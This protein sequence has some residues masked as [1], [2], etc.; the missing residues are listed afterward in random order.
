MG[1]RLSALVSLVT[2]TRLP[3]AGFWEGRGVLVTGHTGFKGS[4]LVHWLARLGAR[5]HGLALDPP[6]T[7]S[8]FDTA[9]TGDLLASDTRADVR[10]AD[11]VRTA[12][13]SS[14]ASIVL[15]LAAQPLVRDG[16]RHPSETFETNVIGTTNLLE[17][18]RVT[19]DVAAL[20]VVTTDKVYRPRDPSSAEQDVPHRESDALGAED[21]YAWS[22]VMVEHA[23][24][25]FHDLPAIDGLPGWSAPVATARAGNVVGGGDWSSERLVPDCIRAFL[26]GRVVQLRYPSAVRPWQHVL[27]PLNGYLLLAES[28]VTGAVLSEGEVP[29]FNFGPDAEGE[30]TVGEVASAIADRWGGSAGVSVAPEASEPPENPLLRLDSMR[31]R[32]RLGWSPRWDHATTL[33]RTADW[34]RRAAA[35]E[36][37]ADLIGEQLVDFTG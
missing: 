5:V 32:E 13:R 25:A 28:L 20:V 22:K 11:A 16:Y 14:G 8:L 4:W 12:V 2:P 23:V 7:P 27:E 21:P 19:A 29:A 10:D 34:Y 26:D 1:E 18:V 30:R 6:T 33:A 9:M 3:D 35:G 15:H 36:D 17:A 31:A 37:P 24:L